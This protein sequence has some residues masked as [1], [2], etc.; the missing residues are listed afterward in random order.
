[1][2]FATISDDLRKTSEV[3][4]TLIDSILTETAKLFAINRVCYSRFK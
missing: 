2:S 3:V 1:M 4:A